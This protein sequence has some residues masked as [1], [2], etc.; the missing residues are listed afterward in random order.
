[1][2]PLSLGAS[3]PGTQGLQL[4]RRHRRAAAA[5]ITLGSFA[6]ILSTTV[7]NVAIPTLQRVFHAP[8]TDIQWILSGF[9]LGLSAVIPVSGY[10]SDRFGTKRVY[11][12]SIALFAAFSVLCGSAWSTPSL[13]AFRVLQGLAGGMVMPV[14]MTIL[15]GLSE[16]HE[17]GRMMAVL[18]VPML[19]APALGP[20]I[21][22]WLIQNSDWRLIFFVNVPVGILALVFGAVALRDST[23]RRAGR[24]DLVGLLLATPG[25]TLLVFGLTQGSRAG[26]GAAP[27]VVPIAFGLLLIAVF[28]GW[29]L[30]HAH[31]LL[32]LRVFRDAGFSG[33]MVTN[34]IVAS[35]LFGAIFLVPVFTQEIQG[36]S[37]LSAG[38]LLLPQ[39]LA[40]AA[41]MP[42]SGILTDRI[43][44]RPV[45]LL[46]LTL[47]A[48]STFWLTTVTIDTS[49]TT[50]VE[51]LTLRGAATGLTMMP[52]FTAA[53]VSI[54]AILLARATALANT[55]QRIASSLG[56]AILATVVEIRVRAHA[57]PQLRE[58]TL[59]A[60]H[61]AA[62]A[63]FD[64][65]FWL[66]AGMIL[67]GLPAAM[68]LRRPLGRTTTG[69]APTAVSHPPLSLGTRIVAIA[70]LV[71]AVAGLGYALT[72]TF[73]P[74]VPAPLS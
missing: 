49:T 29:D 6:S 58:I 9:L 7:V 48:V 57:P 74:A 56:I 28:V 24:I 25:V 45:V 14:G 39:G 52:A 21:G 51:V 54:P 68:L 30:R 17:R 12:T 13:I 64:D 37:A 60:A 35:A 44:A 3:L 70:L 61:A 5:I 67:L 2:P 20:T 34:V 40:A 26:W 63:G 38:L 73:Y 11:L 4:S 42:I 43:G 22:G 46:G 33:A 50:W 32:D 15:M 62:G 72:R 23:P 66:A 10:L 59:G 31:P 27:T 36:Y 55:I 47:M 71:I 41:L 19:L 18:G 16:P 1:M 53:Y 69:G 8:L 65:T